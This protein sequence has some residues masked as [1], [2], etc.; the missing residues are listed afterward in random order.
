MSERWLNCTVFKGMFSDELV[1]VIRTKSGEAVSFFVPSERVNRI[2]DEQ[3]QVRVRTFQEKADSW[4]VVP[5]ETQSV[6][7]VDESQFAI[8]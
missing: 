1:V 5:N 6:V 7:S 2:K 8:A 4:A 3:G